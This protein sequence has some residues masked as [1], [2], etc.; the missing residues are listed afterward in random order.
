MLHQRIAE[1]CREL[2]TCYSEQLP[3]IW[4]DPMGCRWRL[5]WAGPQMVD[6]KRPDTL[7]PRIE[8]RVRMGDFQLAYAPDPSEPWEPPPVQVP[9][10]PTEEMVKRAATEITVE[11]DAVV[12]YEDWSQD[13]AGAEES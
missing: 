1:V 10:V 7:G 9:A 12:V 8:R 3:R 6:L 5:S 2:Q 11:P 4:I 13:M